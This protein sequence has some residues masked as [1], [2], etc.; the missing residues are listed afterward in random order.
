[1]HAAA[2]LFPALALLAVSLGGGCAHLDDR[3]E[4]MRSGPQF[5]PTNLAGEPFLGGIRR[6]VLLPIWGGQVASPESAAELDNVFLTALQQQNRF[7]VVTLS[8]VEC[9][10]R[11]RAEALSSSGALP[12]DL[13]AVLKR[14]FA[15]DAVMFVDLTAFHA[16]RPL[17]LGLRAK[18][19]TIDGTRLVWTF[20]TIFSAADP[21]VAN[22]ARRHFHSTLRDEVP[23]DRTEAVLQS[24]SRFATYAAATMFG[25]LP[26][27]TEPVVIPRTAAK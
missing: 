25:T 20:D 22:S 10:R 15:A 21:A 18:L 2:K 24:P 4:V 1:M 8:R 17:E 13:L 16:Y 7:E 6:V 14:E 23:A 26:P 5:T 3:I 12:H 9:L 11:F 19:A 27:V